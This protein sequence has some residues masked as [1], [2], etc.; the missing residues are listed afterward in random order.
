MGKDY[1]LNT[2]L[3]PEHGNFQKINRHSFTR[4]RLFVG[5]I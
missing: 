5:C 4:N 2:C 1:N 3:L